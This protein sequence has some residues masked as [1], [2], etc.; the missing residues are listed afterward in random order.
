[1]FKNEKTKDIFKSDTFW[2]FSIPMQ[3]IFLAILDCYVILNIQKCGKID[4][5]SFDK[6][7]NEYICHP[8]SFLDWSII[9]ITT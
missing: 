7:R 1:M 8:T 4:V 9:L 3:E 2:S 6:M 5:C